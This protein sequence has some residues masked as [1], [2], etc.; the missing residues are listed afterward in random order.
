[1]P[2]GYREA[3][4]HFAERRIWAKKRELHGPKPVRVHVARIEDVTEDIAPAEAATA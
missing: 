4:E 3:A 1:M 2:T